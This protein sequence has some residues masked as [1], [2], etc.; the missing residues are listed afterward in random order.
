[1]IISP[2]PFQIKNLCSGTAG[3]SGECLSVRAEKLKQGKAADKQKTV[4]SDNGRQ[5]GG[6]ASRLAPCR[7]LWG[8]RINKLRCEVF[9]TRNTFDANFEVKIVSTVVLLLKEK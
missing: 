6:L 1:M 4:L 9:Y 2:M 3:Q 8:G 7:M 5:D